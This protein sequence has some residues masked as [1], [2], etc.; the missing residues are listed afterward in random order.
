[1]RSTSLVLIHRRPPEPRVNTIRP[2]SHHRLH[3]V[4]CIPTAFAN[5]LVVNSFAPV[6]STLPFCGLF[7]L[8]MFDQVLCFLLSTYKGLREKHGFDKYLKTI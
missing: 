1:M 7:L 2:S 8:A 6:L 3:V 4:A 5:W